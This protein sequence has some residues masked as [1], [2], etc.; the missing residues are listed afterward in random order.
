VPV[1]APWQGQ[2]DAVL[3]SLQVQLPTGLVAVYLHGSAAL[4]GWRPGSDLDVL[5]VVEDG[6]LAAWER[7]AG[8]VLETAL[9][10]P[11]VPVELSAVTASVAAAPSY[12]VPYLFHVNSAEQRYGL[13]RGQGDPDLLAHVAVARA[14]GIV[15]LGPPPGAVLATVP[16]DLLLTYLRGELAWGLQHADATYAVLNACRAAA[17]DESGVL[18]SKVDGAAWGARRWPEHAALIGA[19]LTAHQQGESLGGAGPEARAFVG[20][21]AAGMDSG[22]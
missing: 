10:D 12:D 3:H 21:V 6:L 15:L 16:R 2:A 1:S 13:D 8:A 7:V 14:A 9:G 22:M 4:G 11:G 19:A 20:S 18:L 17:Y 5:V